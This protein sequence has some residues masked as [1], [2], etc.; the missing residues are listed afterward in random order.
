MAEPNLQERDCTELCKSVQHGNIICGTLTK[1]QVFD[2]DM[3]A[4]LQLLCS[5]CEN[6][7]DS[8][9][10]TALHIAA[11]C[12]RLNVIKWLLK[13]K[14]ANINAKD[15]ESGYTPLHRSIFYGKINV[16]VH[17]IKMGA[18]LTITDF[19]GLTSLEHAMKDCWRSVGLRDIHHGEVYVWGSN[20]NY[21]FGTQEARLTPELLYA[22]HKEYPNLQ[23]DQICLEKFHCI[24]VSSDGKVYGCG[25]G[26]GG[27]LGL[28]SEKTVITPKQIKLSASGHAN[29]VVCKRASIA[30][31]HSIFLSDSGHVWTT[32][33][34]THRVL[35]INPP[36]SQ[37]LV[38]CP[39]PLLHHPIQ[40]VCAA[41]YHSVAWG[42]TG[43]Y[44]WGLHGGQLGHSKSEKYI[45][46]PKLVTVIF[47]HEAKVIAVAVSVGATA[48]LTS[49][50]DVYIMNEYHCRLILKKQLNLISISVVGGKLN[51]KLDNSLSSE[52]HHELKVIALSNVGNL[53]L[54]QNSSPQF[55][56]CI[57]SINRSLSVRQ[58]VFNLN[59][60][61]FVTNEGEAF[62]GI[63]KPRKIKTVE[64]NLQ[65]QKSDFHEFIDSGHLIKIS[66]IP[67]VHRALSIHSDLKGNNYVVLQAHPRIFVKKFPLISRSLMEENMNVFLQDT[68]ED[69]AIQD[70]IFRVVNSYFPA[71]R[72]IIA[73]C[74]S[75]LNDLILKSKD[76]RV[77]DITD[78]HPEIFEQMLLFVYC[79]TCQLLQNGKW[80]LSSHIC[81]SKE[82]G[83][84]ALCVENKNPVRLLQDAS[85]RFGVKTLQKLLDNVFYDNECVTVKSK[86]I[87]TVT[88]KFFRKSFPELHDV[89]LKTKDEVKVP[90]HKCILA[91]RL[92]YFNSLFSVRWNEDATTKEVSLPFPYSISIQLIEFL[93][94]DEL[95]LLSNEDVDHICQLLII[96]DQLFVIRLKEI[97]EFT[98]T[99]H[100]TLKNVSQM[101][102]FASIYNADQLK[103]HCMEFI[104]VNLSSILEMRLLDSLDDEILSDITEFYSK[105]N[106]I[107]EYRV[108]TPYSFAPSDETVVSA[109]NTLQ[110]SLEDEDGSYGLVKS[111]TKT[112]KRRTRTRKNNVGGN[113]NVQQN[114]EENILESTD[115]KYIE[116]DEVLRV[117]SRLRALENAKRVL[118]LDDNNEF[119]KLNQLNKN[120]FPELSC[121][122]TSHSKAPNKLDKTESKYIKIT[123]LSQKQRKRLSSESSLK[124]P[125]NPWKIPSPLS[126]SP[127][128]PGHSFVAMQTIITE[129]RKQKQNLVKMKAKLLIHTQIE[130]KAI[131][132]LHKFY[133]VENVFD[134]TIIIQR[135]PNTLIASPVGVRYMLLEKHADP[136]LIIVDTG[137]SPFHLVIGNVSEEFTIKTTKLILQCGGDPNVQTDDGLTPLHIA[138]AWG[139]MEIVQLLLHFGADYDIRDANFLTP[140]DYALRHKYF[141]IAQLL[142][143]THCANIDKDNFEETKKF[144]V[145]LDKIIVNTG[146]AQAEYEVNKNVNP[147]SSSLSKL[148]ELPQTSPSE[149]VRNWC[150]QHSSKMIDA[151]ENLESD[152]NENFLVPFKCIHNKTTVPT[153][154]KNVNNKI[155]RPNRNVLEFLHLEYESS[156]KF[157][158]QKEGFG[159]FKTESRESGILTISSS[160]S[161]EN[162]IILTDDMEKLSLNDT[163]VTTEQ[164]K[165]T[166][167]DYFTCNE[168]SETENV[169]EKNIFSIS[170]SSSEVKPDAKNDFDLIL[171]KTLLNSFIEYNVTNHDSSFIS[172]AEVYKYTDDKEGIVL[173][174]KRI[175][176]N[177]HSDSDNEVVSQSSKLSSLP[178]SFD[179]DPEALRMELTQYG[180]SAGPITHTTKRVYLKKLYR[181]K[182]QPKPTNTNLLNPTNKVY[183]K[184]LEKTLQNPN[185]LKDVAYKNLEEVLFKDFHNPDLTRKWRE[186]VN[187]SSFSYLLLDPRLT[188]NLP[189]RAENMALEEVWKIFLDSI[190]Y[191]GKGKRTRPYSH[192]YEAVNVWQSATL[193]SSDEKIQHILDIWKDNYG[194][195]CLHV[196]QNVIPVEAYTREAAMINALTIDNLKN[197]RAGQFYGAS[198]TWTC[199][200]QNMLGAFLL[201]KSMHIFLNEGEMQLRPNDIN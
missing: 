115:F 195:V 178:A 170:S 47:G 79:G 121:S 53:Y 94:T 4:Y 184:E 2:C 42:P 116:S 193:N 26:Q 70:V 197:N 122:P 102:S 1:R 154:I 67:N 62:R 145:T 201:Y 45:V 113:K 136:N 32:G 65:I 194:V 104:C 97:C 57:F 13:F 139:R 20:T 38:P 76:G 66:K 106:P 33:L 7:K 166:S 134:E 157:L 179:Y 11:S 17:L 41:K 164:N 25:H 175:V 35:G 88:P 81:A 78:V 31:D 155:R 59:E 86:S 44:T 149:Y 60:I 143:D 29:P 160:S 185:C 90:A 183:S 141:E 95:P 27:R 68:T 176:K 108:I 58:V 75:K 128:D 199:D 146:S 77:V 64:N 140:T 51:D 111:I 114:P 73:S 18:N 156:D 40:D 87:K 127:T 91:A 123:K 85:K 190:F 22:L 163:C 181:L 14:H 80:K 118:I 16:A 152:K 126:C 180:F 72:Y 103:S 110:F 142:Y 177:L 83:K 169:F 8:M 107:M 186:G 71:H 191:V 182:Q 43:I 36:P 129:E 147:P 150:D 49:K 167:S 82:G 117:K 196:F 92:E 98:L 55:A 100:V 24:L 172:V 119:T 39:L 159:K 133:N 89:I 37:I 30:L 9:G 105:F 187:K 10:R 192:L 153:E 158:K 63:I 120:D 54:W 21:T 74:T 50:G 188:R 165:E 162:S 137:I 84:C 48:V 131:E 198:M 23:V 125:K 101:I 138:A 200:K 96:A 61:L 135:V 5:C 6:V 34:N 168:T 3:C 151:M 173:L 132:D 161:I 144:V 56:R 189:N 171:N 93:Y 12:G 69:D 15:R 19:N 124:S 52:V 112:Q 109:S 174:E 148:K 28:G 130:D 99:S 46:S